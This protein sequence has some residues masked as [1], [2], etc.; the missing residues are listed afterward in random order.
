M[1]W[2]GMQV[3]QTPYHGLVRRRAVL[4]LEAGIFGLEL[5]Q[6][7]GNPLLVPAA[8]GLDSEAVHRLREGYRSQMNIVLVV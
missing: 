7:I 8:L 5:V 3:T 2:V 6:H 4:Y 1:K